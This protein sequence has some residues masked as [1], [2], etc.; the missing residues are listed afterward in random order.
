MERNAKQ[1]ELKNKYMHIINTEVWPHSKSMQDYAAKTAAYI[2]ELEN[3]DITDIDKPRIET[4]FCFGAGYCG[5]STKEEWNEAAAMA[6]HARTSQEYFISENLKE[7]DYYISQLSDYANIKAYKRVKYNGSPADSKL[8]AI[9][10]CRYWESPRT[11]HN[12]ES[13]AELTIAEREAIIAGYQE[14]KKAFIKRLNTYLKRYGLSKID[15]WTY[16]VD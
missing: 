8:K 6:D 1:I 2:V 10:L 13:P 4:R 9:D 16:L 11:G 14:V 5:M 12:E 7:L 3:G 15:S